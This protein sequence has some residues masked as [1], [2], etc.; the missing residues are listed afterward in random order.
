[1]FF[2][3]WRL[4]PDSMLGRH[5]HLSGLRALDDSLTGCT[6]QIRSLE[7]LAKAAQCVGWSGER[8]MRLRNGWFQRLIPERAMAAGDAVIGF[9]TSSWILAQRAKDLGKPFVLDRTAIHRSTRSSIRAGFEAKSLG[10]GVPPSSPIDMQ[11]DLES[12]ELNL[13][14]RV[15]VASRFAQR[16]LMDAGIAAEKTAVIPYG[17]NAAWFADGCSRMGLAEKAVFLYAGNLRVDK[18]VG[19]LLAAWRKLGASGAELW[20]VGEGDPAVVQLARG[21]SGVRL[22]GKLDSAGLREAYQSA[23]AFV[24]P[25][26]YDGFGM[27]LLEAMACGLPIIATPNCAAPELVQDG[28]AGLICPA[29]DSAGLAAAMADVISHGASWV[30]RGAAAREI[31]K[32][33]SWETYGNRWA[34]LLREVVK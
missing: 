9:D 28:A 6:T 22:L 13:A 10:D 2:T 21:V 26:Y 31:A 34:A 15:V 11:D 25:T 8:L 14:S 3:G 1:M 18:G 5:L 30:Q 12:N 27:V 16:S 4:Q 17:V 7:L 23:T 20:L 24:F 19:V 29:G 33:Y 32:A